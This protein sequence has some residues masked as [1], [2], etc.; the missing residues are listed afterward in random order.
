MIFKIEQASNGWILE[1]INEEYPEDNE[2]YVMND[3]EDE[4]DAFISLLHIITSNFGPSTSRYSA[5][6]VHT[7]AVPG[8][9][10]EGEVPKEIKENV[11]WLSYLARNR[12]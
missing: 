11:E 5:K 2:K 12:E 3:G 1:S 8:D 10:F 6:R 7:I 9:K 4:V